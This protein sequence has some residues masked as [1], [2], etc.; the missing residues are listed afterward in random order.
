ME[1]QKE[2]TFSCRDRE[3]LK[4]NAQN[5]FSFSSRLS[6]ECGIEPINDIP[7]NVKLEISNQKKKEESEKQQTET[8]PKINI[9]I[10]KPSLIESIHRIF[11]KK[12]IINRVT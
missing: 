9:N 1:V 2:I 12:Q 4:K 7:E 11:E 10:T 8:K 5:F 3:T 6:L